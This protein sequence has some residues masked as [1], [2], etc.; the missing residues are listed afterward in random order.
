MTRESGAGGVISSCQVVSQGYR[1]STLR[2]P[3]SEFLINTELTPTISVIIP[4]YNRAHS[5]GR[6]LD[7]VFAQGFADLEVIVVDDGSTDG[8]P[9]LCEARS[10]PRLRTLRH[11]ANRGAA[12][13]RNTGIGAALG[14]YCALLDSDDAWFPDKLE[15]QLAFLRGRGGHCQACCTGYRILDG[16]GSRD[17][18]PAPVERQ[19]LLLGCDLSP[20]STLLAERAVFAEV[21]PFDEAL[22]RYEDWDWLLRYDRDHELAVLP[23]PLAVIHFSPQR[24]A[25]GIESSARG[26]LERYGAELLTLG[27]LGRKARGLRWLE[28]ARYYALERRPGK[29]ALNLARA[30]GSY[31]FYGPGSL[32]LLLDAW[33]GTRLEARALGVRDRLRRLLE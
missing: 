12:A 1:A 33:L 29:F 22:P 16:R 8:T 30:F 20:G 23:D 14:V 28:V 5:I 4:A 6:A 25:A 2:P 3:R 26:F 15:R 18:R 17:Y 21:G 27:R 7:S 24:S 9:D 10:E 32:L 13:A 31:P 11:G 19:R